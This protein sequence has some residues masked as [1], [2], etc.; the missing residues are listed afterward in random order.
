SS[1]K[2]DKIKVENI[3]TTSAKIKPADGSNDFTGEVDVTFSIKKTS[4]KL[5]D[6]LTSD[7]RTLG[8]IDNNNAET[9][10]N[11]VLKKDSSLKNDK[12]KVENI[13]TTSAKIKP[14]DGSNDFTGEV[15]V[16]FSIKK[17]EKKKENKSSINYVL[18]IA[19]IS[20]T[21][22]IVVLL[23]LFYNKKNK[24]LN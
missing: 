13:T 20:I 15:D 24:Y 19:L 1:L 11:V 14:A 6:V 18:I 3:T 8:E 17:T 9:I 23:V 4:R 22:I 7:K 16:T 21:S 5:D 10:K 2:N 12:I